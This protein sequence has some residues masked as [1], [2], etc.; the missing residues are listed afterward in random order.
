MKTL[1]CLKYPRLLPG[2]NGEHLLSILI[3]LRV[4]STLSNLI[5]TITP[6]VGIIIPI[7]KRQTKA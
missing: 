1:S 3:V 4:L 7:L 2:Y 6:K 5:L